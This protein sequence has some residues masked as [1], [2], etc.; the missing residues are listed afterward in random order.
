MKTVNALKRHAL[1]LISTFIFLVFLYYYTSPALSLLSMPRSSQW[2][3]GDGTDPTPLPF[4]YD[5]TIRAFKNDPGA[6]L[7]GSVFSNQINAPL[8]MPLFLSY[9]ERIFVVTIGNIVNGDTILTY[10]ILCQFFL[11]F[12]SMYYLGNLKKWPYWVTMAIA[13]CFTFA[14]YTRARATVH[15]GLVGIYSVP[16]IFCA[17]ELLKQDSIRTIQKVWASAL[18]VFAMMAAPYYVVI[19]IFLAPFFLVFSLM[20]RDGPRQKRLIIKRLSIAVL[21]VVVLL[22]V[23]KFVPISPALQSHQAEMPKPQA[24][25]AAFFLN[26]FGN[27]PIDF[28]LSD[29]S[30]ELFDWNPIRESLTRHVKY[31]MTSGNYHERTNGIRWSIW[32]ALLIGIAYFIYKKKW[33]P[34]TTFFLILSLFCFLCSMSPNDLTFFDISFS[35]SLLYHKFIPE[36]RVTSRFGVFVAFGVLMVVGIALSRLHS[37][38]KQLNSSPVTCG[39][40]GLILVLDYSFPGQLTVDAISPRSVAQGDH[41]GRALYLPYVS[42][43][44]P[45]QRMTEYY[46]VLQK[47]RGTDCALLNQHAVSPLDR[48][49]AESLTDPLSVERRIARVVGCANIESIIFWERND[50]SEKICSIVN[51]KWAQLVCHPD[52]LFTQSRPKTELPSEILKCVNGS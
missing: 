33:T 14:P 40:I 3:I 6:F 19:S 8:G 21:P 45:W 31:N 20:N 15:P 35:P 23:Q 5:A 7:F 38:L 22:G 46:R 25:D 32:L 1:L 18:L 26:Q 12:F 9:F 10:F 13:L 27:K 48:Y 34:E 37:D 16:L 11:N 17:I 36:Y 39:L 52:P 42:H 30:V 49:F 28:F 50:I 41:C 4:L 43:T 24:G 44:A 29:M 47:I 2:M 51:G